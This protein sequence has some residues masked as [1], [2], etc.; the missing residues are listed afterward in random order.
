MWRKLIVLIVLFARPAH[1]ERILDLGGGTETAHVTNYLQSATVLTNGTFFATNS[2]TYAT[3]PGGTVT[4]AAGARLVFPDQDRSRN[5]LRVDRPGAC[6]MLLD[7][8]IWEVFSHRDKDNYSHY[9]GYG[10]DPDVAPVLEVRNGGR[11]HLGLPFGA[12]SNGAV[13]N[14]YHFTLG[15]YGGW[16]PTATLLGR[17]APDG[18]FTF[19]GRIYIGLSAYG[20]VACT[21]CA[22]AAENIVFGSLGV[23]NGRIGGAALLSF[24]GGSRVT[25]KG[26]VQGA[27]GT[28]A[29]VIFDDAVVCARASEPGDAVN[30]QTNFFGAA[31]GEKTY[32][33]GPG[34]LLF[35]NAGLD[36]TLAQPFH[37]E[38][39][40]R[41]EGSGTTRI[42][43][44]QPFT[45]TL[46]LG[47]ACAFRPARG[48]VFAGPVAVTD[49]AAL[50][51][52]AIPPGHNHVR[53]FS[54]PAIDGLAGR[55]DAQHR[56]F[57]TLPGRAGLELHWGSRPGTELRVR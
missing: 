32:R 56:H 25:T 9:W 50:E 1:A 27:N 23:I 14:R 35:D 43:C 19:D 18:G 30:A 21:N 37:G 46:V 53:L 40:L 54:A 17:D 28:L 2:G 10:G 33:L 41:L 22:F 42:V 5:Y 26:F 29:E 39:P 7:G 51:R 34:G 44:D 31:A 55:K 6:R 36:V 13:S 24:A 52:P 38:G 20:I 47:R 8:G 3:F 48:L 49:E 57:F 15:Y 4:L 45:G 12:T 11:F 16:E